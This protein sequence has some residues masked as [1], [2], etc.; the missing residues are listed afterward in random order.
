MLVCASHRQLVP[1][2]GARHSKCTGAEERNKGADYKVATSG[3]SEY[4]SGTLCGFREGRRKP[5]AQ[6]ACF[7][8]ISINVIKNS[9]FLSSISGIWTTSVFG[10]SIMW[11]ASYT[12]CLFSSPA[13]V[14]NPHIVLSLG[15]KETHITSHSH[16]ECL[17][18]GTVMPVLRSVR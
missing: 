4:G 16:S 13:T 15:S 3:R 6:R 14:T 9:D 8:G 11:I 18:S 1:G 2:L 17:E 12:C 7:V 5:R 10:G